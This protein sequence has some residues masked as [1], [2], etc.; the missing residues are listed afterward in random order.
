[1]NLPNIIQKNIIDYLDPQTLARVAQVSKEWRTLV[2]RPSVWRQLRW[3]QHR[4]EF[5]YKSEHLPSNIRHIGE[6]TDLCFTSWV[7][8]KLRHL[9]ESFMDNMPRELLLLRNVNEFMTAIKAHWEKINKPC[10]HTHHHKWSDVIK[11]RAHL[12]SLMPNDIARI[13]YRL[14]HYPIAERTNQY[15]YW[16]EE[17]LNDLRS[18][19]IHL[20]NHPIESAPLTDILDI[21]TE[22]VE[23]TNQKRREAYWK[24]R[25]HTK[26]KYHISIRA[27]ARI[28]RVEFDANEQYILKNY[29]Y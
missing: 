28:G 19:D 18:C 3:K 9:N 4:S 22:K 27:L 11:A 15:R 23:K 2:Y 24:L 12:N 5:F 1:M 26:Q 8:S 7:A 6:P 16:L 20:I 13:H 21:L 17:H 29:S 25:E 10:V 14:I